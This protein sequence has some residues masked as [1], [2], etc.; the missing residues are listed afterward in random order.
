MK[1]RASIRK[2]S[3]RHP[4]WWLVP[5]TFSLSFVAGGGCAIV[6]ALAQ[7]SSHAESITAEQS[8]NP[9]VAQVVT[10]ALPALLP[11]GRPRL[12]PLPPAQSVWTCE[13]V[14]IGGSLGGVAA[15]SHAMKAGAT[16]CLI[17]SAPWLGG[18][19]SAQGVSALD[20][21]DTLRQTQSF[22]DSWV[23]F[24]RRIEQQRVRLPAWT[25]LA[26]ERQVADLNSCWVGTLCFLP[27]AG[28]TAAAALLKESSTH[29][30]GSRWGTATRL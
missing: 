30:L 20:E 24:K 19:I 12:F 23:G 9:A 15:A 16:T 3:R 21:S 17:E 2:S 26:A 25:G 27:K 10:P 4:L 28:E 7:Q 5:V 13:V 11:N 29:T 6:I 8:E 1:R 14:V 22:S 18:Q